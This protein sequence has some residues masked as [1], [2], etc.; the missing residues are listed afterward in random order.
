MLDLTAILEAV[1]VIYAHLADLTVAL[2]LWA[3]LLNVN[4]RLRYGAFNTL[5]AL[6]EGKIEK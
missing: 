4:E 1:Y 2:I 3:Y 5:R 6:F